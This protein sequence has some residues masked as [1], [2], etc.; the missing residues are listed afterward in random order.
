[1]TLYICI[2]FDGTI[3][4]H[5][6]PSIGIPVPYAIKWMKRWIELDA[7]LILFTMRS[8]QGLKEAIHYLDENDLKFYGYN[9]N[10]T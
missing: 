6:Y 2:D 3:V 5:A 8:K 9:H 10:P 4:D 1:M 7:R